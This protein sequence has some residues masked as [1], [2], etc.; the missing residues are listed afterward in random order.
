MKRIKNFRKE[1]LNKGDLL[2][3]YRGTIQGVIMLKGN[4]KRDAMATKIFN[5]V[6]GAY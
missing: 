4:T 1:K 3:I 2:V 5:V 6:A